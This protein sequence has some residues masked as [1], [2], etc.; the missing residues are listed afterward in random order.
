MMNKIQHFPS[1]LWRLL[2]LALPLAACTSEVTDEVPDTGASPIA[3][4]TAE[5]TKAVKNDFTNGDAFFVWGWYSDNAT[6]VSTNVF[7]NVPVTYNGTAWT[8]TGGDRYWTFG[9]TYDFY[10]VYPTTVNADVATDG[11]ITVSDFDCS[12]SV[13]L[14]T[15]EETD[16]TYNTG[17]P[18]HAVSFTFRHELARVNVVVQVDPGV[19]VTDL[20]ATLKGFHDTGTLTR[21]ATGASWN[22]WTANDDGKQSEPN[23]DIEPSTSKDLFGDLLLIPQPTDGITLSLNLKRDGQDVSYTARFDESLT[24]WSAGQAYRYVLHIQVDAITFSNFTA[25][26]WGETHTGGDINIGGGT[27]QGN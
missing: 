5:V 1:R 20:S 8:Y 7:D 19:T 12:N 15:A 3:F 25:D 9:N 4:R 22:S 2:A 10:A 11:T 17:D 27:N 6:N 23:I 16:I 21:T 18:T 14:M 24:Q 13:D 26:K